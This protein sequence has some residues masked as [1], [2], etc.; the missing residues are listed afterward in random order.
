[1]YAKSD[2]LQKAQKMLEELSFQ[3]VISWNALIVG[4]A[5]QRQHRKLYVVHRRCEART[6][7]Q[8]RGNGN[9]RSRAGKFR[10]SAVSL[11]LVSVLT[12]LVFLAA[13]LGNFSFSG[14]KD[15]SETLTN[16]GADDKNLYALQQIE[17]LFPR[18]VLNV[19]RTNTDDSGPLSL[20]VI[21]RKDLSSSWVVEKPVK[22]SKAKGIT[23]QANLT[24][25]E[26]R[27]K[28][29]LSSSFSLA[30]VRRE[31]LDVHEVDERHIQEVV[32]I[33]K[34]GG[35]QSAREPS[36]TNNDTAI[37]RLARLQTR[38]ERKDKRVFE[39]TQGS[40]TAASR[41][42][43][44]VSQRKKEVDDNVLNKYSIW[45]P[46]FD[47]DSD[48]LVRLIRDQLI[49]A[50]VYASLAHSHNMIDLQR[51]LNM[52]IKE[53]RRVLGEANLDVDLPRRSP[54]S[55]QLPKL[56]FFLVS[57][58]FSNYVNILVITSW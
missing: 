13:R 10:I 29:S 25:T 56:Q 23:S 39:L 35:E 41:I 27:E 55:I 11:L 34:E 57:Y 1:M 58:V 17:S 20:N 7:L 3:N 12:P 44:E 33:G 2:V 51:E 19:I 42:V 24:E 5:Q 9:P 40:E 16:T 21:G 45:R 48:T 26:S 49:M 4:Y 38:L 53:S 30:S 28:G 37:E 46:E 43:K 50:R 15:L 36:S 47:A 54:S 6:S 18:D 14:D 8:I 52:H 31:T 22:V 32:E